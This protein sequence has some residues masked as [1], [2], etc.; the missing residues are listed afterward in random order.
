[1]EKEPTPE[2]PA[3]DM[4]LLKE[5]AEKRAIGFFGIGRFLFEFSQLGLPV[6]LM[7]KVPFSALRRI[8]QTATFCCFRESPPT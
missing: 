3:I 8:T 1:M 6:H 7:S 5:S 2:N 4:A